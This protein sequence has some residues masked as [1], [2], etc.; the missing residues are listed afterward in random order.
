MDILNDNYF[1]NYTKKIIEKFYEENFIVL[2]NAA[3]DID[4]LSQESYIAMMDTISKTKNFDSYEK[5]HK[6]KLLT[7]GVVWHLSNLVRDSR[8][9]T[10]FMAPFGLLEEDEEKTTNLVLYELEDLKFKR[11]FELRV[12][13]SDLAMVLDE[14]SYNII[15]KY[16]IENKTFR[17]IGKELSYSAKHIKNLYDAKLLEIRELKNKGVL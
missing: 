8:R 16:L 13:L 15:Y 4:D 5:E 14:I 10:Q 6:M 2:K 3:M 17:E 7:I 11:D 12:R 9:T 1:K